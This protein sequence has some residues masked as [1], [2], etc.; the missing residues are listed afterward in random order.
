MSFISKHL[1]FEKLAALAEGGL[2]EDE[3]A[4]SLKH[5]SRCNRCEAK[6]AGLASLMA[7][8]RKDVAEDAPR[9][10]IA[11]AIGLFRPREQKVRRLSAILRF[12][13]LQMSPAYGVRSARAGA[14]QILYSAGDYDID[15]RVVP[16]DEAWVISGQVF[17]EDCMGGRIELEGATGMSQSALNNQCEFTLPPVPSGSYNFRLCLSDAQVEIPQLELGA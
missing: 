5:V 13:S 10:L 2:A 9:P 1:P 17:G 11:S 15:L 6:L 7:L 14:R 12:D 16:Q 8:M 3:R 4:E